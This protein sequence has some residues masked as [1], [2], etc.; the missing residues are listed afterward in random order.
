MDQ[1]PLRVCLI[2]LP[3][4]GKT[5]YIAALWAYLRSGLDDTKY[6]VLQVPEDTTYLNLIAKAWLERRDMPRSSP[7]VSTVE[8]TIQCPD[9]QATT[10]VVPDLPGEMFLNAVRRP[11]M[12]TGAAAAIVSSTLLLVFVNGQ[13]ATTFAP[14]GD[15]E[16]PN[17]GDQDRDLDDDEDT[18]FEEDLPESALSGFEIG[19]AG[20]ADEPEMTDHTRA[21]PEFQISDL[22]S[23]TLNTELMQRVVYLLRDRRLPPIVVVVS[24]W[25]VLDQTGKTPEQ[26]LAHEQPMTWQYIDELKRQ[27][28]VGVIGVSAQGAD[29]GDNPQIHQTSA[30]DRA[31]GRDAQLNKT[32]IAAP[33]L[34]FNPAAGTAETDV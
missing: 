34:W 22:D 12:D 28:H 18:P 13:K 27:T 17:G 10:V 9:G 5:T 4:T 30:K 7:G 6:R 29:Y 19:I 31:W 3:G 16:P 20:D 25:D 21:L 23:D 8:F 32:D 1:A 33:L 14:L 11:A 24:A 2:G 26:W 15:Q